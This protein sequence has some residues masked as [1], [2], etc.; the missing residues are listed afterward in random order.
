MLRIEIEHSGGNV[1]VRCEGALLRGA[2]LQRLPEVA[3]YANGKSVVLDLDRVRRI[4]AH[5]IGIVAAMAQEVRDSGSE[6]KL[7]RVPAQ[8]R[9]VLATCGLEALL[10]N[11][12]E[13]RTSAA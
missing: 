8:L 7:V 6:L 13:A 9:A 2:D 4:D 5:G 12:G 1:C 3:R 11:N 10:E